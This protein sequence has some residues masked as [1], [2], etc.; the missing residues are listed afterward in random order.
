MCRSDNAGPYWDVWT[1][2][3]VKTVNQLV[4]CSGATTPSEDNT[5]FFRSIDSVSYNQ[6]T[7]MTHKSLILLLKCVDQDT[8][9][10]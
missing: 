9:N 3:K 10:S 5:V 4:H 2:R 8:F 6:P 1:A 7:G